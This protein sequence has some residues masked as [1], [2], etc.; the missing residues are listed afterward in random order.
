MWG[1]QCPDTIVLKFNFL[2][3]IH[4]LKKNHDFNVLGMYD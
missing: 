4:I 1:L 2:V 3:Y